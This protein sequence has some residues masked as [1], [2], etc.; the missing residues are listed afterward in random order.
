MNSSQLITKTSFL[1]LS[2]CLFNGCATF[3]DISTVKNVKAWERNILAQD[4]MKLEGDA[5][6]AYVDD[7]I[8]FSKEASS[9]GKSVGGGGCGCN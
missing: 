9:G 6:D 7:H 1:L 4:N 2:C 8:Y 5:I 3:K